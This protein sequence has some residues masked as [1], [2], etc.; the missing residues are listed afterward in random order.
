MKYFGHQPL[1]ALVTALSTGATRGQK[2]VRLPRTAQNCAIL[3]IL[4]SYGLIHGWSEH[5]K[6]LCVDLRYVHGRPALRAIRRVSKS[7]KRVYMRARQLDQGSPYWNLNILSTDQ[8]ILAHT[9]AWVSNLGGEHL[10]E[11]NGSLS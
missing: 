4:S 6:D 2:N 7:Q 1:D 10:L 8:G 3:D 5:K 11:V 9:D